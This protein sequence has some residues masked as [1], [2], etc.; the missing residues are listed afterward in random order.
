MLRQYLAQLYGV[1]LPDYVDVSDPTAIETLSTDLLSQI[2]ASEPGVT[3]T[4]VDK[5]RID[6]ILA[7][8]KKRL[9]AYPK[10]VS[11]SGRSVRSY[12]GFDYS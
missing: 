8:A 5:P 11:L 12:R 6:M 7:Q 10:R 2:Q 3:V 1:R 9:E 4:R